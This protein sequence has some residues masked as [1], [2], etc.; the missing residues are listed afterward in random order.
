MLLARKKTQQS[1]FGSVSW[2][3]TAFIPFM[4]YK[5]LNLP[6]GIKLIVGRF[7]KKRFKTVVRQV[8]GVT[9]VEN[10]FKDSKEVPLLSCFKYTIE[11]EKN[12]S[13]CNP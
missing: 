4:W 12:F 3:Y 9:W 1:F 13:Q 10:L 5:Y 6:L 8:V 11:V 2:D 7:A